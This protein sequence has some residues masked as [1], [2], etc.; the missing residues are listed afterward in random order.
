MINPSIRKRGVPA[1]DE[2]P[3]PVLMYP[4]QHELPTESSGQEACRAGE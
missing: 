4:V 1:E 2:A 3:N